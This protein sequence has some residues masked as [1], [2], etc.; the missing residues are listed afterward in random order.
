MFTHFDFYSKKIIRRRIEEFIGDAQYIVGYGKYLKDETGTPF[1]SFKKDEIDFILSKGLDVYRSVWDLNST[2]AVLDVEYFNL[3]YP[4]E[5]YLRPERVFGILEEVYNVIIEEFSRYKIRPLSTVTGQGYHFIFKISR[6]STSGKELEKIGY[7][8]P[9][10]EKRYRMI[11]GRKRRTV[12][13]REGKA[14]DGMGR[15]LEYFTYKVM[16]RLQE[17]RFKFPV[18]ITDVAVG[19]GEVGRE[20]VSIDLSM[21]GDP[22]YM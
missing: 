8:S 17:V 21:Y 18:Q 11:R 6:Y 22:I 19:R 7:V 9:T 20:A 15:I 14:F 5:V 12:S 1:R 4:G 10:L 3:D 16:R 2:L 13:V